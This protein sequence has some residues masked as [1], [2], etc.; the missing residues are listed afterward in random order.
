MSMMQQMTPPPP[1]PVAPPPP[2]PQV[3][4]PPPVATAPPPPAGAPQVGMM[5]MG[6]AADIVAGNAAAPPAPAPAAGT[7]PPMGAAAVAPPPA[8]AAPPPAAPSGPAAAAATRD[9]DEPPLPDKD[10]RDLRLQYKNYLQTCVRKGRTPA[11]AIV[12]MVTRLAREKPPTEAEAEE[13]EQIK[14][15]ERQCNLS[16]HLAPGEAAAAPPAVSSEDEQPQQ[17]VDVT[18]TPT[19]REQMKAYLKSVQERGVELTPEQKQMIAEMEADDELL[20]QSG[21]VDFM[22]GA[23]VLSP[24]EYAARESAGQGVPAAVAAPP[25]A[26]AA[27]PAAV[28]APPAAVAAPAPTTYMPPMG[29]AAAPVYAPAAAPVVPDSPVDPQTARMWAMQ[30]A[31]LETAVGLLG[32]MTTPGGG[33]D[34]AQVFQLRKSLSSLIY[35]LSSAPMIM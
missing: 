30:A 12:S 17:R 26:V 16:I 19:L 1:A 3:A 33:L 25:A 10:P 13:I 14:I 7:M 6:T 8:P 2:P 34:A 9:A 21:R 24:E 29:A 22:K 20:D 5:M 32:L 31:E 27:A 23:E 35:T 18:S 11:D 4:P 15:L 28:A